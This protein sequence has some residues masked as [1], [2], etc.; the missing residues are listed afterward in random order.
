MQ[1]GSLVALNSKE[2]KLSLVDLLSVCAS[3]AY[4]VLELGFEPAFGSSRNQR[5]NT[6]THLQMPYNEL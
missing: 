3:Y 2:E 1:S 5:L 4:S 6:L